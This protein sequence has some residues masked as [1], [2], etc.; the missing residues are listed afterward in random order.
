[1]LECFRK[2]EVPVGVDTLDKIKSLFELFEPGSLARYEF[3]RE[4]IK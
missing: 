3:I 2:A 1:M 4:A